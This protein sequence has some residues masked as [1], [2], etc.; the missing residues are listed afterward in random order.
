M[1]LFKY[2]I[3]RRDFGFILY[4]EGS[5][6]KYPTPLFDLDEVDVMQ[7]LLEAFAEDETIKSGSS[8]KIELD[9]RG[10]GPPFFHKVARQMGI[11]TTEL[12]EVLLRKI[13]KT[14]NSV[15]KHITKH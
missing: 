11:T 10:N 6:K 14:T 4:S 7:K 3:V 9:S 13:G 12:Y 1:E 15:E 8:L 5:V 2:A